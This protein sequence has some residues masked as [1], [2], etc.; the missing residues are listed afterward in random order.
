MNQQVLIGEIEQSLESIRLALVERPAEFS[1]STAGPALERAAAGLLKLQNAF[2]ITP[3]ADESELETE[4]RQ[5]LLLS[6]RVQALYRQAMT[7]YGGLAS[8][9]VA[10]GAWDAASYGPDGLVRA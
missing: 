3:P 1:P 10:N 2:A 6:N 5:L 8:E 4:L 7:F 9:L